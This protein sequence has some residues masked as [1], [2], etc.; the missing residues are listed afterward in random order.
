MPVSL[1]SLVRKVFVFVVINALD[2][3]SGLLVQLFKNPG[4][5]DLEQDKRTGFDQLGQKP[6]NLSSIGLIG[7]DIVVN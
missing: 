4:V 3:K 2:V 7:K 6:V 1:E 5:L